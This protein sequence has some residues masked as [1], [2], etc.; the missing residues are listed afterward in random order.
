MKI[1]ELL[2]HLQDLKVRVWAQDGELKVSAP[3]G[4]LT[5]ELRAEL[6]ARKAEIL[7]VLSARESAGTSSS[8]PPIPRVPRNGD[9]PLSFT[10]QRIWF[11]DQLEP[12][13]ATYNMWIPCRMGG[14]LDIP[15][16]ERALTEI[17]R[18]HEVLRTTFPSEGGVPSQVISQPTPVELEVIA[19][20]D[21]EDLDDDAIQVMLHERLDHPFDLARDLMYRFT[22]VRAGED[23]HVFFTMVHHAAFDGVSATVYFRELTELYEAFCRGLASP[24]PELP[25]QY[26]DYATWQRKLFGGPEPYQMDYWKRVLDGMPPVLDL[27]FDHPRPAY[28]THG[29]TIAWRRLPDGLIDDLHFIGQREGATLFMVV[30]AAF[31]A[32]LHHITGRV[33]IPVGAPIAGRNCA[34]IENLV[35]F[36]VNTL[37]L[38]TNLEGEPSFRELVV[39]VRDVSVG[40][41]DHQDLPFQLLV[42]ALQMERSLNHTPLFQTLFVLD[43]DPGDE[44][45]MG[46]LKLTDF[47]VENRAARTDLVFI[48]YRGRDGFFAWFEYNTDLFEHETIERML[49]NFEHLLVGLAAQP[50]RP[51]S[52][53]ELLTEEERNQLLV[54]WNDTRTPYPSE[55]VHVQFE[56]QVERSPEATA[57][58]FPGP[59]GDER[60]TYREL[61]RSANR[62]AR[63]LVELGVGRGDLVGLCLDRS[64]LMVAA[65]LAI[66]KTGA[67]Y[68]PLDPTFPADRLAYMVSDARLELVVTT[69]ELASFLPPDTRFA[70][71]DDMAEEIAAA[72]A[73]RLNVAVDVEDRM[74]VIYTSGS[75]GL[76]KGVEVEHRSVSNFLASM[77]REPGL[78]AGDSLLAITTLSFDISVLELFL[79]L[80][81][82]ATAIVAPKET[83]IDGE[84][85]AALIESHRP[86]AMQATPATWRMLIQ[87]G[88]T[89]SPDLRIFCGGEALPRELANELVERGA[90]VWNL[91]GPT[92]TTVWSAVSRVEAGDGPVSIGRPIANTSVYVLDANRRPVAIGVS[93]ELWIGGGGLARGYL[94]RA[95]LTTERF[96]DDPFAG[97]GRMYTTGDLACWRAD[98][99]LECLGRT[100]NQVKLRGFRIELGEIES[101]LSEE[102]GVE[103]CVCVVREDT[104]GDQR[105]VAYWAPDGGRKPAPGDLRERASGVLPAYMVPAAFIELDELPLTPNRKVD[106]KALLERE[107]ELAAS[108]PGAEQAAPRNEVERTIAEIWGAVLGVGEVPIHTNFF[109]LGGHSLLLAQVR[110]GLVDALGLQVSIVD[111]FQYPTVSALAAHLGASETG[112]SSAAAD[113]R[114]KERGRSLAAGRQKLRRRRRTRE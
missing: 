66:Q 44:R 79:P 32:Y 85:L 61:D 60:L 68:V 24:L 5:A 3:K 94:D 22:L 28:Q 82:G 99:T 100:D 16:L 103:Q 76:P 13:L 50:D 27:P 91:Y 58:V 55:P 105:L 93:G 39:R 4:A 84:A 23:D 17:V 15:A 106:R 18:R 35:G 21:G 104:P 90:E 54:D 69:G 10:Q 51:I 71:L 43:E 37:V 110:V 14:P 48:G 75:T 8:L 42:D 47:D 2:A 74:Y 101:V 96:V 108:A 89:G 49:K 52:E 112:R 102:P 81:T 65:Q 53:I 73:T 86:S 83:T 95:E 9:L 114:P 59:E 46:E 92:E 72:D 62:L 109:D 77:A 80:T 31:K 29:G 1:F 57:L 38:R 97:E 78:A 111:L 87:S 36:F 88:W 26:A 34:E 98:G 20:P 70:R 25:V 45:T 30:L 113:R 107:P 67:A 40:A 64:T 63:R 12:N 6:G 19:G 11:L 33:D 41:L 7:A 56:A